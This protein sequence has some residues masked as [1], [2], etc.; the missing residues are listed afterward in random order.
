MNQFHT[1]LSEYKTRIIRLEIAPLI[2]TLGG[3][4]PRE[5][6]SEPTPDVSQLYLDSPHQKDLPQNVAN[7][8]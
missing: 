4:F 7:L 5:M 2:Y 6:A 1:Y 3:R 8:V